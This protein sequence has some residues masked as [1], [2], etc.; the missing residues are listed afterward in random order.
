MKLVEE[1]TQETEIDLNLVE[2]VIIMDS[3]SNHYPTILVFNNS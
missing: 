3:K 2:V 1:W